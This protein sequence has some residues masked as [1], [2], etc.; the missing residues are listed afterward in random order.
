MEPCFTHGIATHILNGVS[1]QVTTPAR[2]VV[3][4]FKYRSRIG[5]E[6]CLEALKDV[7]VNTQY[8]VKPDEI[9]KFAKLQRVSNVIRPY[10]E[11]LVA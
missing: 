5:L 9:M 11:A 1:V 3:D 10:L 2:T 6:V 7:C 8:D 4:C